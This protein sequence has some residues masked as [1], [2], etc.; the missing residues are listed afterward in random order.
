MRGLGLLERGTVYSKPALGMEFFHFSL[1]CCPLYVEALR[2][3]HPVLEV[4]QKVLKVSLFQKFSLNSNRPEDLIHKLCKLQI[5]KK[6][7]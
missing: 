2:V 4:L 1:L 5:S 3:D 6:M 7:E